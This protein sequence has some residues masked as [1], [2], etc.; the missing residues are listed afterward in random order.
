MSLEQ[1]LALVVALVA[2]AV[3]L[4]GILTQKISI[5]WNADDEPDHWVYGW[6]AIAVGCICVLAS[7]FL[8]AAAI[9][10]VPLSFDWHD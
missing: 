5:D 10:L 4:K 7:F 8:F 9:G 2:F 6:H 3:G 1:V